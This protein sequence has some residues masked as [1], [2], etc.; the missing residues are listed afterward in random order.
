M[1]ESPDI[2]ES[3]EDIMSIEAWDKILEHRLRQLKT[4]STAKNSEMSSEQLVTECKKA[5]QEG[6]IQNKNRS[7]VGLF[8]SFDDKVMERLVGTLQYK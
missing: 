3:I 5:V 2:I 7:I 1:P 6:V 4:R 8:S